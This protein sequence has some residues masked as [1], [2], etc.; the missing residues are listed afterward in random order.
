MFDVSESMQGTGFPC[1]RKDKGSIAEESGAALVFLLAGCS[2]FLPVISFVR[3]AEEM[4]EH[5]CVEVLREANSW[6][7]EAARK[8]APT[9]NSLLPAERWMSQLGS[10]GPSGVQ[11]MAL[12]GAVAGYGDRGVEGA[13]YGSRGGYL[14][15]DNSGDG[16]WII[17]QR[18]AD[19]V[20]SR[21]RVHGDVLACSAS[22]GEAVRILVLAADVLQH[23]ADAAFREG[24]PSSFEDAAGVAA[25]IPARKG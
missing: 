4:W 23:D 24:A 6:P 5:R 19:D 25:G 7:R 8:A 18:S 1:M 3:S 14:F 20:S 22:H 15:R 12:P 21:A 10:D 13:A 9:G 16:W 11:Y 17:F 2:G